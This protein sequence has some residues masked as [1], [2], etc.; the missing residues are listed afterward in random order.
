M[1]LTVS[2]QT[3]GRTIAI[4]EKD[5]FTDDDIN[6]YQIGSSCQVD[7][8]IIQF[9]ANGNIIPSGATNIVATKTLE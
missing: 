7:G 9:D 3:C 4:A 2:C 8:P 5:N 6:M 1:K